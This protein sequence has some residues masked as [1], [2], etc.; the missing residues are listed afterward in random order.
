MQGG[1]EDGPLDGELKG[2]FLQEIVEN[3]ADPET[4]P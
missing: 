2:S 4:L 3:L 1:D